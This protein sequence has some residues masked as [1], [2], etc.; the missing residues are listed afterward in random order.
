MSQKIINLININKKKADPGFMSDS[1]L[2]DAFLEIPKISSINENNKQHEKMN[3][4]VEIEYPISQ[5]FQVLKIKIS[6]HLL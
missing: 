1:S 5:E 4:R 2:P 6:F 3:S